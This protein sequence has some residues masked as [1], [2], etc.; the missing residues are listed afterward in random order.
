MP[1][2]SAPAALWAPSNI[3]VRSK[4]FLISKR[5]AQ[6]ARAKPSR[7]VSSLMASSCSITN[8]TACNA[9]AKLTD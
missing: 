7:I 4:A 2:D 5:P 6:V 3:N 1:N 8:R 9:Q